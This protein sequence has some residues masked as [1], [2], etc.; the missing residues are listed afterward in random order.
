M[1]SNA[2]ARTLALI[3]LLALLAACNG[4]D[5]PAV[6]GGGSIPGGT[7][8]ADHACADAFASVPMDAIAAAGGLRLYYGHTSHGSQ[9]VTG[10]A[11]IAADNDAYVRPAIREVGADL[12]TLGDLAWA[13]TT[14][15]WLA[16]PLPTRSTWCCG[17]GAAVSPTNTPAGIDAYLQAMTRL[18]RRLPGDHLHLHDR[19]PGRHRARRHA[20]R[21][22]RADPRLLRRQRQVRCSTSRTSRATT[23][24]A[25]T[26]PTKPTPAAGA[27]IGAPVM[28]A[29]T[30]AAAPTATASTAG[31]RARP[32]GGCW[33]GSPAGTAARPRTRRSP[34]SAAPP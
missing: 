18:E 21:Q 9:L 14:R 24:T 22:Q 7:L 11:M 15:A 5:D 29:R 31:A 16:E 23:P 25:S 26:T 30:E 13:T 17:P 4:S 34:T 8:K 19:P 10:L 28:T 6:P 1:R 20:L 2:Q 32:S 12:G 27:R 3:A 33:R